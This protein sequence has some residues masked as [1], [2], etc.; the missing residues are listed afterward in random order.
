MISTHERIILITIGLV[1]LLGA[2]V[3]SCR[4]RVTVEKIPME[5]LPSV[6]ARGEPE[7]SPD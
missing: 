4:S 6:P 2:V 1:L 3:K 7:P 5:N